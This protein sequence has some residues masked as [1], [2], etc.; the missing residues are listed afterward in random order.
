MNSN[1]SGLLKASS[2][3][4]YQAATGGPGTAYYNEGGDQGQVASYNKA[5]LGNMNFYDQ[6]YFI[7]DA[8]SWLAPGV[9]PA[10]SLKAAGNGATL[11]GKSVEKLKK[12]TAEW[13]IS[14][15]PELAGEKALQEISGV[16]AP[17]GVVGKTIQGISTATKEPLAKT[18][19]NKPAK[20]NAQYKGTYL[21]GYIE[22]K[23]V[24]KPVLGK[25]K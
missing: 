9:L 3:L 6:A 12:P 18:S 11:I 16:N 7:T 10:K 20:Q 24:V 15:G 17:K 5:P 2:V 22:S 14:W 1:L 25:T 23:S 19:Q 13:S 4:P 8:A 21:P